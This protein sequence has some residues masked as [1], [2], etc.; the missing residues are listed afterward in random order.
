MPQWG[1]AA[2]T[3]YAILVGGLPL[4]MEYEADG[5]IYPGYL[6]EL[7]NPGHVQACSSQG[8][9]IIGIAD[10][11]MADQDG[12]GTRRDYNCDDN[13]TADEDLPYQ[14]HDQVKVISGPITV[15]I[16]LGQENTITAGDKLQCGAQ[17]GKADEYLCLTTADPCAL[18][19]ESLVDA[20]TGTGECE[21]IW[22]KLL[23]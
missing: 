7:T 19:A 4:F 3:D 5:T 1:T 10:M 20:D 6:V 11:A 21:Y 22:V 23:I 12:H 14:T 17:A 9:D 18:V 16:V 2:M 15:M 8:A 13:T